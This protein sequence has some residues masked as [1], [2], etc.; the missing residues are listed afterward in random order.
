MY[1]FNKYANA[2]RLLR[3]SQLNLRNARIQSDLVTQPT[4]LLNVVPLLSKILHA[5]FECTW[6]HLPFVWGRDE[7]AKVVYS[8]TCVE[9]TG[10]LTSHKNTLC[11]D[12]DAGDDYQTMVTMRTA[13]GATNRLVHALVHRDTAPREQRR[14]IAKGRAPRLRACACSVPPCA[15]ACRPDVVCP[16][17]RPLHH[18]DAATR[19][20]VAGTFPVVTGW[21]ERTQTLLEYLIDMLHPDALDESW[22]RSSPARSLNPKP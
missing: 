3:Q 2:C 13:A 11:M 12:M 20:A 6:I 18:T 14:I 21:N 4:V 8:I 15:R 9:M 17:A 16:L 19:T 5:C 10:L 1:F 7:P 22:R